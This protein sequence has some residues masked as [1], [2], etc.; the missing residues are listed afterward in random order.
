MEFREYGMSQYANCNMYELK[1]EKK[2]IGCKVSE[3]Q[4]QWDDNVK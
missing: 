4:C 3:L 2:S 1:N